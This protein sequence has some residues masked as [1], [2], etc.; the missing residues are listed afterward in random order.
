MQSTQH[1]PLRIVIV[2]ATSTM[3]EHCARLWLQSAPAELVLVGRDEARLQRVASD[4]AVRSPTSTIEIRTTDFV[5]GAAIHHFVATLCSTRTPDLV[6]I[7]HGT[8]PNQDTCQ[9]NLSACREALEINGVSP[10]LFAEAFVT[11]MQLADR[12]TLIIIGSVAGDRGRK[13]NYVYGSAKGMVTR[14]AQGLQHRLA[15]AKS[16]LKVV[17]VKPGPTA[18]PMTA[19]MVG[20]GPALASVEEVARTIVAG[21]AKGKAVVY[22]PG[23][24]FVIM[25]IIRHLPTW[26][27]NKINI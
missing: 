25:M 23:K 19:H 18:T 5:D 8:L 1:S 7:A 14:Y 17:L 15:L 22:A 9:L 12:G 26:I 11:H 27:F 16:H 3:A 13:S 24:W 21:A 2:G 4:L 6:L 10:V 20:Q